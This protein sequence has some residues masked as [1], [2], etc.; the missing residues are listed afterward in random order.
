M[1]TE[2]RRLQRGVLV[3]VVE[4]H[5]RRASRLSSNTRR[6]TPLADSLRMAPDAVDLATL[7]RVGGLLLDGLEVWYGISDTTMRV[8]PLSVSSISATGPHLHRA[9]PGAV[10]VEMMPARPRI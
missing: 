5:Q 1:L 4:D 10:G 8:P 3:Q 6:V 2:K 9:A 7:D